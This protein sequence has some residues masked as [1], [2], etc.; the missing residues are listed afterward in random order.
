MWTVHCQKPGI[1]VDA[2][3]FTDLV[4]ADGTFFFIPMTQEAII[5]LL[6]FSSSAS[7]FGLHVFCS[8]T[9]IQN[10]GSAHSHQRPDITVDGNIVEQ[11]DNFIHLNSMESVSQTWSS[12][13]LLHHQLCCPYDKFGAIGTYLCLPKSMFTRL[14]LLILTHDFETW[15]LLT[16]WKGSKPSTWNANAK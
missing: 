15:S 7:I 8:K 14:V 2:R 5:C 1:D 9:T 13:T 3:R 10:V 11:V 6:C 16:T 4:F 12:A